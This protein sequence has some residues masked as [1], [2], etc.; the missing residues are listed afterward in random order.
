MTAAQ[1]PAVSAIGG[2]NW[3]R[4]RTDLDA[5]AAAASGGAEI[6]DRCFE[7][8]Q[9]L[10]VFRTLLPHS[11]GGAESDPLDAMALIEGIAAVNGSAGWVAFVG[12]TGASFAA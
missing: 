1:E 2:A 11:L 10:G 3:E 5:A 4:W 6:S 8:L 12:V 9:E 7:L